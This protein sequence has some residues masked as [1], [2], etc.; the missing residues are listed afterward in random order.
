ME[1]SGLREILGPMSRENVDLARR[2]IAAHSVRDWTA[3][4]EIW[5]PDIEL[6]V[7]P[8]L[9]LVA[10]A[11]TFRGI[12]EIRPLFESLSD[13]YSDYRVEANEVID[14]GDRVVTVERIAGRGL[15][16]SGAEGWVHE[17]LFR[18]MSFK[19]GRIWRIK[20]YP[21]RAEALEAAGLSD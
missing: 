8:K 6:V 12:G 7:L 18:L 4:A 16:G 1:S 19:G 3:L 5:H 17:D 2:E 21:S 20:E 14:A 13:L 9:E 11:G 15:K 10:G